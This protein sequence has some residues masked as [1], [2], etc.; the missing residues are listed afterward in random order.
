MA[1][2]WCHLAPTCYNHPGRWCC[3]TNRLEWHGSHGLWRHTG[4]D[5]R[6][7]ESLEWRAVHD[8]FSG[9]YCL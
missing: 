4:H 3:H 8:V 5:G 9:C 2:L 6:S 7:L 1:Q